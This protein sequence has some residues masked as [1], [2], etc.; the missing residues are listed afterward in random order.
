M[1]EDEIEALRAQAGGGGESPHLGQAA[2]RLAAAEAR[3][4]EA[5]ATMVQA[6]FRGRR[7]RRHLRSKGAVGL[8]VLDGGLG[9]P[10]NLPAPVTG[11]GA[12]SAAELHLGEATDRMAAAEAR[13]QAAAATLLQAAYRGRRSRR[14]LEPD[15][16]DSVDTSG[17][18]HDTGAEGREAQDHDD[19]QAGGE[20]EPSSGAEVGK[21]RETAVAQGAQAC[22][23]GGA[24]WLEELGTIIGLEQLLEES[25][26]A[27]A[28]L[29]AQK[30]RGGPPPLPARSGRP[31]PSP[32]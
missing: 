4:R 10:P 16:D 31:A 11:S 3:H 5:A 12:G 28:A 22:E 8:A 15:D 32:G 25:E 23:L 7:S 26:G 9:D 6:H 19:E 29:R 27:L 30:P 17:E 21:P 24:P 14:P 18:D 2:S 1:Q 20:A 13:R